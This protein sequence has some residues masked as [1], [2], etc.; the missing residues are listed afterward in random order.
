MDQATGNHKVYL[1]HDFPLRLFLHLAELFGANFLKWRCHFLISYCLIC[2][3]TS[4]DSKKTDAC[5]RPSASSA[6]SSPAISALALLRA[7]ALARRFLARRNCCCCCCCPPLASSSTSASGSPSSVS[8]AIFY[9]MRTQHMR[10]TPLL[11]P[12][13]KGF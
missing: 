1:S 8:S 3:E 6:A 10:L 4:L 12:S 2:E 5:S 13:S 7:A 9:L 11:F